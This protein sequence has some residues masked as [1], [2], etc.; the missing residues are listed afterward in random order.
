M[1]IVQAIQFLSKSDVAGDYY[2]FGVFQGK[3][4]ATAYNIHSDTEKFQRHF[5]GFDSFSGLPHLEKDDQ[6][7][8]YEAFYQGQYSCDEASVRANLLANGVP[9][10]RFT[11]IKGFYSTSLIDPDLQMQLGDSQAALIHIDCDLYSSSADCLAFIGDR[12]VDGSILMFDDWFCF[13]G[14]PDKG[15][16]RAYYEWSERVNLTFT[17]YFK[18]SWAGIAF[19]CHHSGSK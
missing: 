15:V 4:L 16:R 17:E 12:I 3:S 14:R 19:I 18:Y 13:R 11:L 7:D 5:Y 9:E 6:L 10:D 1:A 8:G 2:E